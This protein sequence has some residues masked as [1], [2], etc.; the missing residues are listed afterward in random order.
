MVVS[1]YTLPAD[2]EHVTY[3]S[4][5]IGRNYSCNLCDLWL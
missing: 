4:A 1:V 2:C 5:E 3:Q